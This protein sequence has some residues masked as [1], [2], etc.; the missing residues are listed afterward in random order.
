MMT[1]KTNPTSKEA[2]NKKKTIWQILMAIAMIVVLFSIASFLE[3]NKALALLENEGYNAF[4]QQMPSEYINFINE[5]PLDSIVDRNEARAKK[6]RVLKYNAHILENGYARE[7]VVIRKLQN[8]DTTQLRP[9]SFNIYPKNKALAVEGKAFFKLTADAITYRYKSHNYRVAKQLLPNI[10]IYKIEPYSK[11]WKTTISE[12][13][14]NILSIGE[15]KKSID[16]GNKESFFKG[17]DIDYNSYDFLFAKQLE[18]KKILF[19]P[20]QQ[21][22]K[23]TNF[24]EGSQVFQEYIKKNE[25]QLVKTANDIEFWQ[26]LTQEKKMGELQFFNTDSIKIN[27]MHIFVFS[28]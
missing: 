28:N 2:G 14:N 22:P 11:Y 27:Q 21:Q 20:K 4:Y 12:V 16:I 25:L 9:I 17:L 7:L 6:N 15:A 13:D 5:K 26:K 23:N 18:A 24:P 8:N 10:A 3:K 1:S 19:L